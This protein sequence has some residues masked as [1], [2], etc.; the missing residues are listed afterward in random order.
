MWVPD[1]SSSSSGGKR[2]FVLSDDSDEDASDDEDLIS[3]RSHE[4]KRLRNQIFSV[5]LKNPHYQPLP[6]YCPSVTKEM[7]SGFDVIC[8]KLT[9]KIQKLG[10][11]PEF[12]TYEEEIREELGSLEE[13]GYD[14][15]KMKD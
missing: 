15:Q 13:M 1:E 12:L 14:V 4:F 11:T 6:K 10:D 8:V 2:K 3:C 7:K 5:L 9:Q